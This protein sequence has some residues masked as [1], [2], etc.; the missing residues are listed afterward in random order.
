MSII[1]SKAHAKSGAPDHSARFEIQLTSWLGK[2]AHQN[3]SMAS[4]IGAGKCK[5][6][7]TF[8]TSAETIE[9]KKKE[10]DKAKYSTLNLQPTKLIFEEPTF[11]YKNSS[12]NSSSGLLGTTEK[13]IQPIATD[14][15]ISTS[16]NVI[17]NDTI[18]DLTTDGDNSNMSENRGN[19]SWKKPIDYSSKK[20]FK[21]KKRKIEA[22][23]NVQDFD[24]QT[25]Y[26]T[27]I[28]KK[29]KKRLRWNSKE[30]NIFR[31]GV[32]K[33]GP[34]NWAEILRDKESEYLRQRG[35][36]NINLKDKWRNIN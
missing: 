30:V 27:K 35:R 33:H 20:V 6:G 24:I 34:G 1:S 8:S 29:P 26:V 31:A 2:I 4:N 18:I 32:E 21:T 12:S 5:P 7:F 16:T 3:L 11:G 25:P 14:T 22:L 36:T 10:D 17:E 19:H 15:N 28:E 9:K 23:D 13:I